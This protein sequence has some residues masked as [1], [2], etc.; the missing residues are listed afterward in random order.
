MTLQELRLSQFVDRKGE[1]NRFCQML[2]TRQKPIMVVTGDSG[3]GKSSLLARMLHECS[4]RSIRKAEATWTDTRNYNYL[5]VMRKIRDDFGAAHFS[6]FTTLVNAY[7]DPTMKVELTINAAG[8]V[9]VASGAQIAS[10]AHVGNIAGISIEQG[11]ALVRDCMFVSPRNDLDVSEDER[12]P[13]LTDQFLTDLATVSANATV[14]MFFDSVEKMT[15]ETCAWMWDE[16]MTAICDGRLPNVCAVLC[17]KTKPAISN[18]LRQLVEDA[19]LGPLGV[20]DVVEYLEKRGVPGTLEVL[21]MIAKF[22]LSSGG[23][24]PLAVANAVDSYFEKFRS[25]A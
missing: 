14:V 4:R 17:G 16:L 15:T 3:F 9:S 1:M 8:G 11:A 10:G 19:I 24:Q 7:F 2:D 21:Q 18:D 6:A 22:I 12:R 5:A 23:G 13:R 25:A 20:E